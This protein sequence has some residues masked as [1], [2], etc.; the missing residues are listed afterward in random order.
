MVY[1][2]AAERPGIGNGVRFLLARFLRLSPVYWLATFAA[3]AIAVLLERGFHQDALDAGRILAS[4]FYWP[5][6]NPDGSFFPVIGPGWTL[7]YEMMFYVVF[8]IGIAGFGRLGLWFTA[9]ILVGMMLAGL[10]LPIRQPQLAFWCNTILLEFAFGMVLGWL[11][12]NGSPMR[13]EVCLGLMALGFL[14]YLLPYFGEFVRTPWRPVLFG[15]PALCVVTGAAFG[16]LHGYFRRF[17]LGE[18][19]GDASYSIYLTHPFTIRGLTMVQGHLPFRLSPWLFVIV[20]LVLIVVVGVLVAKLFEIP[21]HRLTRRWLRRTPARR[22]VPSQAST[23]ALPSRE[24]HRP[25]D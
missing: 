9:I 7:D 5:H 25:A 3:V 19:I 10:L 22:G 15:L 18:T 21:V 11:V 17:R 6:L 13:R 2:Y 14:V 8:A 23:E 1:S 12:L 24:G 4:L 16:D 20:G